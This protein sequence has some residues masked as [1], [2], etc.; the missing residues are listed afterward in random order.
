M[1]YKPNAHIPGL[2][3]KLEDYRNVR[4]ALNVAQNEGRSSR[5]HRMAVYG[6]AVRLCDEL[7]L[8]MFGVLLRDTD[9]DTDPEPQA[10]PVPVCLGDAA[11]CLT[12]T[13]ERD[14]QRQVGEIIDE[15]LDHG[16]AA[17][18]LRDGEAEPGLVAGVRSCGSVAVWMG[19]GRLL[20]RPL[21]KLTA[22]G[23]QAGVGGEITYT[24]GDTMRGALHDVGIVLRETVPADS[25]DQPIKGEDNRVWL[26]HR[27]ED[28]DDI[29]V[30]HFVSTEQ[31]HVA[32]G[33]PKVRASWRVDVED[34][35]DEVSLPLS[36]RV[37]LQDAT[38]VAQ[39]VDA[40]L[41]AAGVPYRCL[42]T[43]PE[44]SP[45][46]W[47]R[48]YLVADDT[49]P[50]KGDREPVQPIPVEPAENA[51]SSSSETPAEDGWETL[52]ARKSEV[53]VSPFFDL[54]LPRKPS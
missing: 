17:D 25:A 52:A 21:S 41:E 6:A 45:T 18:V 35:T 11:G 49:R 36:D 43:H 5:D 8:A 4:Q 3:E 24:P 12:T 47:R 27:I 30:I 31:I 29:R 26:A 15:D 53:K 46:G 9:D 42:L 51:K 14:D 44:G 54:F 37:S 39:T 13:P 7:D 34:V 38:A 28:R 32:S 22:H 10:E 40:W 1:R 23:W 2:V 33:D 19:D 50:S 16:Q 48:A 20:I